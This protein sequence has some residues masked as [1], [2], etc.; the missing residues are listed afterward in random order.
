MPRNLDMTALRSFVTVAD[1]EGFTRAAGLLNLTQSAV[2]M[3]V[4]RLEE[5][6]GLQLFDRRG[7]GAALTAAGEQLLGYGR[8]ML[9]L[10]DEVYERLTAQEFEGEIRLGVPHDIVLPAVPRV[11]QGFAADYPRVRVR[12]S[13]SFTRQLKSQLARGELDVIVTTENDTGPG[14]ERLASLPLVWVGAPGGQAHLRRPLRLAHESQ[15]IFRDG[16]H[17]ALDAAGI[18]WESAV[19]SDSTRTVEATV[20]ADLA[21]NTMLEGTEP[22]HLERISHQGALP[23][24]PLYHVNMFVAPGPGAPAQDGLIALLRQVYGAL[25][26]S[27]P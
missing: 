15:C 1:A 25:T 11:L 12:L 5:A 19:E 4:K 17:A 10:N 20:G 16:V 23:A 6:L 2:S 13:S 24:L 18:A 3:Q 7:R 14:A 27:R 22:P 21:V 9:A 26:P 8:R